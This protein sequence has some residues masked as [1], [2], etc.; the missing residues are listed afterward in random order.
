MPNRFTMTFLPLALTA[1]VLAG[2]SS[3]GD[4]LM[5]TAS[6]PEQPRVDPA[7]VTLTAQIDSL[8][9]DGIADKIEKAAAKKYKMTPLDL[10]KA[11]QLNKANADFQSRCSTLAPRSQQAAAG[12]APSG[13]GAQ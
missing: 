11:D 3:M 5:T 1:G 13:A 12:A 7:C 2:C 6:I 10:A 9:K 8:R 4:G